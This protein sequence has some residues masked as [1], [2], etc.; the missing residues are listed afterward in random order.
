[1]SVLKSMFLLSLTCL[2]VL[3]IFA[4][5]QKES[6]ILSDLEK[7][8]TGASIGINDLPWDASGVSFRWWRKGGSGREMTINKS[9]LIGNYGRRKMTE[10]DSIGMET[11]ETHEKRLIFPGITYY[12]L[13]RKALSPEGMYLVK[14]IGFGTGFDISYD[15][16]SPLEDGFSRDYKYYSGNIKLS[17]PVG[18]EHFF[19]EKF[20]NVSYSLS[21]DINGSLSFSY[22]KEKTEYPDDYTLQSRDI[23]DWDITPSFGI[24]P[25]FYLRVYF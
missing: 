16:V 13:N 5:T 6:L 2:F 24:S 17:F 19:W 23:T 21:A 3:P 18:V 11:E 10:E 20:P 1:M 12:F 22:R 15:E 4:E 25:A 9:S 7:Y 14:G 8:R